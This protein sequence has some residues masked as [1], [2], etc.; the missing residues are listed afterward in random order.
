MISTTPAGPQ[1]ASAAKPAAGLEDRLGLDDGYALVI[2]T[3]GD[4]QGSL[5]TCG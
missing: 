5:E 4:I 2:E 3:S 1:S